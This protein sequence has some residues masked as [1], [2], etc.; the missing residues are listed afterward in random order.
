MKVS[1]QALYAY[2]QISIADQLICSSVGFRNSRLIGLSDISFTVSKFTVPVYVVSMCQRS[3]RRTV[4]R[5]HCYLYGYVTTS[6]YTVFL[7]D[8]VFQVTPS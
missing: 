2:F 7:S 5:G 4:P 6:S 1:Y 8:T 3:P